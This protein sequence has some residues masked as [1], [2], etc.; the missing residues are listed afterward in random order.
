M[1]EVTKSPTHYRLLSA[2]KAIGPY[3]REG[4]CKEWFYLFD[5][6]AFCVNDKKSPEKREFWG[7]WMELSPT[8]EGFEAKYHIGRYNLAGEWD[9]DKLPEHAL[10]EVNRTQEEFHKKLEKT[11]KERFALSLSFHDQSIEFV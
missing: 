5:C 4:Q 8:S 9:T 6:L 10:P 2:M 1:S 11:L 3:L 7:W